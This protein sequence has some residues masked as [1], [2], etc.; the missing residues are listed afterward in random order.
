M[1]TGQKYED[2]RLA[3]AHSHDMRCHYIAIGDLAQEVGSQVAAVAAQIFC[4]ASRRIVVVTR[5]D[6][7]RIKHKVNPAIVEVP[8]RG[9]GRE[10]DEKGKNLGDE[11][12]GDDESSVLPTW[13]SNS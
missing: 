7:G 9:D 3:M 1:K 2:S 6:A 12:H 5:N 13:L 11:L 10:Q 8:R 4:L